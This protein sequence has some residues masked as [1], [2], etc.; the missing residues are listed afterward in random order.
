MFSARLVGRLARFHG[1]RSE[2]SSG[3]PSA[4]N[5]PATGQFPVACAISRIPS[6]GC[7][8]PACRARSRPRGRARRRRF[9][10]GAS[11]GGRADA[12]TGL[13]EDLVEALRLLGG[14]R[15][16][17]RIELVEQLERE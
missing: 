2:T 6:R 3:S 12:G 11:T 16:C 15:P 13:R 14:Q 17:H 9:V 8:R 4:V 5:Q 1:Q 7:S 10:R